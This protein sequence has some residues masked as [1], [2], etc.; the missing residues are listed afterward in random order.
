[1]AVFPEPPELTLPALPALPPDGALPPDAALDDP[2]I[3]P[4]AV[5][6]VPPLETP[7]VVVESFDPSAAFDPQP[8]NET[9][10][11]STATKREDD[12]R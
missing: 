4:V 5:P 12:V 6:A 9:V 2:L 1:V 10:A 11:A 8:E 7:P 3:A